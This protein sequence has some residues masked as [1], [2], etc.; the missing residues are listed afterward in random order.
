[1]EQAA[2]YSMKIPVFLEAVSE[3]LEIPQALRKATA[4]IPDVLWLI[5]KHRVGHQQVPVYFARS[6]GLERKAILQHLLNPQ[7]PEF[8]LILTSCRAPL[9][10]DFPLPRQLK[11][12]RLADLL[13]DAPMAEID[14][15]K[16]ARMM[17]NQGSDLT[18]QA[19]PIHFDA[20]TNTL[21]LAGI[22]KPW[23]LNGEKQVKAISYL[24]NEIKKGRAAVAASELLHASGGRS[25]SVLQLFE[26]GP[27]RKYLHTPVRGKWGFFSH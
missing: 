2:I 20:L 3:L 22:A 7:T 23:V 11:V 18:Q 13:S 16:L 1:M 5:G 21:T 17:A 15:E 10:L 19:P 26:G 4:L 8:G 12:I 9:D 14:Q 25:P 27:W 24:A 6:F